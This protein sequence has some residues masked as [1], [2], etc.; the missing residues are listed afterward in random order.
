MCRCLT[1]RRFMSHASK[2][3]QFQNKTYN[4][5]N[6]VFFRSQTKVHT[7]EP[8]LSCGNDLKTSFVYIHVVYLHLTN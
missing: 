3:R 1:S 5:H 8:I 2:T 7:K 6:V 4:L